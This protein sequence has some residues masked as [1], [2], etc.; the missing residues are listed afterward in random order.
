MDHQMR[1]DS[2][3]RWLAAFVGLVSSACSSDDG[4]NGSGASS[5]AC[6]P[7]AQVQCACANGTTSSQVCNADGVSLTPCACDG[8]GG[9]AA[10]GGAIN[11]GAGGA[12]NPVNPGAGG[13][14]APGAGG[15]APG[16]GGTVPPV[17]GTGGVPGAGGDIDPGG[18][19]GA[20][21]GGAFEHC[22][23]E[24]ATSANPITA[25]CGSLTTPT[26]TDITLGPFGALRDSNVGVGFENA[27]NAADMPGSGTCA[28]F[29]A[30]FGEDPER[31]ARLLDTGDLNFALYTVYRPA[32]WP[33][34]PVPIIT[35]GNGTCAQPEGYGALLRF[36]ASHGFLVVAANSRWV[37]TGAA[38]R[39]GLDFAAAANDD[40]SSPYYQ[41]LDTSKMGAMGHSQGSQGTA[42]AAS[43]PRVRSVILFNGGASASKPFLSI[44]G[45]LDIGGLTAAS[46]QSAVNAAP[47]GA[48]LYYHN[49]AGSGGLRG[50]LVLMLT[51]EGVTD[52]TANWWKL[53]LNDDPAVRDYFVGPSCAL[54]N[55][56]SDFNYGQKGL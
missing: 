3:F 43:D 5:A 4:G 1:I 16:A 15:A 14:F 24:T 55:R 6:T 40:P 12:F 46:M 13:T 48:F 10:T 25:A 23:L 44:S 51:P 17:E 27:L 7:G 21:G 56:D 18:A 32:A 22:D 54:C 19:G 2:K 53:L 28:G 29:A 8:A 50:H 31:T 9:P 39:R 49:P 47:K 11:P 20:A 42:A 33:E 52:A 36:V 26:G 34:T 38:M 41:H 45:D 37:G 35:W 30:L